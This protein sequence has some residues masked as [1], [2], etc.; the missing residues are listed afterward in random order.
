KCVE[1]STWPEYFKISTSV[2][3][4]KP[5]K[6]NYATPKMFRPIVL[7]NTL[8][9]LIEK[10][11]SN[12]LQFE[13]VTDLEDYVISRRILG[14]SLRIRHRWKAPIR[15]ILTIPGPSRGAQPL[16]RYGPIIILCAISRV[17]CS[18]IF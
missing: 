6:P 1:L 13:S 17:S 9:K 12:Q 5:N 8:G 3:I 15:R 4:P 11:I 16:R 10:M 7:L 14:R 2:I 18:R